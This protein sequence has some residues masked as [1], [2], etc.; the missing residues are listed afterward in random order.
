MN[1]ST[2]KMN[3]ESFTRVETVQPNLDD[4]LWRQEP[5]TI[6]RMPLAPPSNDDSFDGTSPPRWHASSN[7]ESILR[8][9]DP[10]LYFSDDERRMRYITGRDDPSAEAAFSSRRPGQGP[11][12]KRKT[13]L[14]FEVHPSLVMDDIVASMGAG[15]GDGPDFIEEI[16]GA[17][18]SMGVDEAE[19]PSRGSGELQ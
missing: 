1:K 17:L 11:L 6:V 16:L 3:N 9:R 2:S 12:V 15:L 8:L 14:S 4:R 13:C 19:D 7:D 10:F 18:E 5:G